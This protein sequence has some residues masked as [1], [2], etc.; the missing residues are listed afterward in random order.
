M[1]TGTGNSS[2]RTISKLKSDNHVHAD[3]SDSQN[4]IIKCTC[5]TAFTTRQALLNHIKLRTSQNTYNCM[6]CPCKF[7]RRDYLR[8]HVSC[9]HYT[10][11]KISIKSSKGSRNERVRKRS[12][13]QVNANCKKN[14]ESPR[15]G[16]AS[17]DVEKKQFICLCGLECVRRESLREHIRLKLGLTKFKCDI[18]NAMFW[19]HDYLK[20]H[21]Q[22]VHDLLMSG[23]ACRVCGKVG[24]ESSHA[25]K[26]HHEVFQ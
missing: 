20:S 12:P 19:R 8:N 2:N 5:G 23:Y 7:P 16:V 3:D 18:C 26:K 4:G 14:L 24:F 10:S 17:S 13:G 6:F 15:H 11:T 1:A 25:V 21:L 22:R 9:I